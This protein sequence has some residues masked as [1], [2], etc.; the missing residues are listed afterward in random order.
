MTESPLSAAVRRGIGW[1]C[2][3]AVVSG[4]VLSVVGI[5][6]GGRPGAPVFMLVFGVLGAGGAM[7]VHFNLTNALSGDEKDHWRKQLQNNSGAPVAALTYLLR[8]D[9]KEA[10]ADISGER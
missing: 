6:A 4:L 8:R 7:I 2:L 1:V 9:L 5:V 3:I 10:T